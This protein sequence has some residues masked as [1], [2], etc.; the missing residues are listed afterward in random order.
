VTGPVTNP[1]P[2]GPGKAEKS[3][4]PNSPKGREVATRFSE[5]LARIEAE[6]EAADLAGQI[7]R[8]A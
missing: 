2:T 7:G 1:P 8:A 3:L 4:D 5:T 6:I